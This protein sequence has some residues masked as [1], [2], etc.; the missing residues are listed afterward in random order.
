[1]E[2]D[3]KLVLLIHRNKEKPEEPAEIIIAKNM[4]GPTG[5]A[6]L[7]FDAKIPDFTDLLEREW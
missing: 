6:E 1:M 3:A 7:H 5:T 4:N 2:Q